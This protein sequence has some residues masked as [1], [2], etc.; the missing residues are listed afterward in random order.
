MEPIAEVYEQLDYIGNEL[1][2][3]QLANNWKH[4]LASRLRPFL[5]GDLLEVGAGMGA[6]VSYLQNDR[7]TRWVSLE[8]DSRL[9]DDYRRQQGGG[10]IPPECEL[11]QGTLKTLPAEQTFD[12]ILYIDV[13]EHLQDDSAEFD[14][15]H[16]RLRPGGHLLILCPAHNFLFS[17]FDTA[18]G[19]FRRYNKRM[20]RELSHRQPVKLEYLDNVGMMA[21]IA[22]KLLLRQSYPSRKQIILWD[23]FFVPLSRVIDPLTFRIAGKSILG[24]WRK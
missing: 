9:C 6:N 23:R 13:L 24:V 2:L 17:P 19:H 7:L 10:K 3:F 11:V 15:A 22:N 18:I 12:S 16:R 8:P 5:R 14:R 20:Y 1:A 21:S 4:Y